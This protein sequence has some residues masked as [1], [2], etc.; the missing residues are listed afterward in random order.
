MSEDQLHNFVVESILTDEE[1]DK[2]PIIASPTDI[3]TE[4]VLTQLKAEVPF[5]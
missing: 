5:K 1:V 3:L 4:I 2:R